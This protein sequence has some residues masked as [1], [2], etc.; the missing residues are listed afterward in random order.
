MNVDENPGSSMPASNSCRLPSSFPLPSPAP[1]SS[2]EPA[3]DERGHNRQPRDWLRHQVL[4][5]QHLKSQE[6]LVGDAKEKL[7]D[8]RTLAHLAWNTDGV[9]AN[10]P[11]V[12]PANEVR[13]FSD[14]V[15]FVK[16]HI[17]YQWVFGSVEQLDAILRELNGY[18]CMDWLLVA[19]EGLET[20]ID[21]FKIRY[22]ETSKSSSR[23][24]CYR[25]RAEHSLLL[26][27]TTPQTPSP[28][29]Q[30]TGVNDDDPWDEVA[31]NEVSSWEDYVNWDQSG[32][33]EGW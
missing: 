6:K 15:G 22:N 2:P 11:A 4:E 9:A 13:D 23:A 20:R 1:T 8:L 25:R 10:P 14:S 28:L 18:C 33:S 5:W 19:M 3:Q 31:N 24:G 27:H 26:G 32:P 16:R 17:Q 7:V 30:V 12:I 21:G 29:R